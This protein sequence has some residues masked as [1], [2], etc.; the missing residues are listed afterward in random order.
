MDGWWG[1]PKEKQLNILIKMTNIDINRQTKTAE[2][3]KRM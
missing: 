3:K 1:K 2:N